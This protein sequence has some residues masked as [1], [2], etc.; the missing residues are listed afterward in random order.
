MKFAMDRGIRKNT[1]G[2]VMTV[3]GNDGSIN[4]GESTDGLFKAC[5]KRNIGIFTP[6]MQQVLLNSTV[7]IAGVGGVGGHTAENLARCGI[8]SLV[9]ADIEPFEHSNINRQ[10]GAALST[11][12]MA[13]VDVIEARIK[14][15]NP[16]CRVTKFSGG[17]N[18]GNLQAFLA[19]ADVVI[20]AID[21]CAPFDKLELYRRSRQKGL[22]VITAPATGLGTLLMCFDPDG[23]TVEEAFA[24]PESAGEIAKHK[25]PIERLMGCVLDYLPAAY[26]E[27]MKSGS[28][29]ISTN[30]TS[31]T[32][33]GSIL[34]SES[35]KLIF[36]NDRENNPERYAHIGEMPLVKVPNCRRID[37]FN[38]NNDGIINIITGKY[39]PEKSF[40]VK[41]GM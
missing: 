4:R 18:S 27:V 5:F 31:C 39:A 36:L 6:E 17:V 21:Y 3:K 40:G 14:D 11:I 37:L 15:I 7:A 34:A 30:S 2:K 33:C 25:I 29:Y 35:M 38:Y 22:F 16:S 23:T 8:G 12:G 1:G 20:D 28:P 19:E 32:L 26:Y 13:K 10:N 9:I 24:Y 41:A